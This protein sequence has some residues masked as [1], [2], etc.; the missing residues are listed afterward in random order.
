MDC[1]Y[2]ILILLKIANMSLHPQARKFNLDSRNDMSEN[3]NEE[4]APVPLVPNP[5]ADWHLQSLVDIV[6]RNPISFSITL[7][8][9]GQ[10][11]TGTLIGGAVYFNEFADSFANG[12]PS[13]DKESM[14][15]IFQKRGDFYAD[16][17]PTDNLRYIHLRN[18]QFVRN[19]NFEPVPGCLWRGK[20]SAVD[21][22]IL[23]G[24][25]PARS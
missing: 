10:F 1:S 17:V 20:I 15:T 19:G 13:D 22:F 4:K 23:G 9:G 25:S 18:A 6:N 16:E 24:M 5:N 7:T 11:L 8:I 21:G 2:A 3:Q 14:R 12:W